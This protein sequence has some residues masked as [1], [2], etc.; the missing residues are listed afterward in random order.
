M[1]TN[2]E[3]ARTDR[4]DEGSCSFVQVMEVVGGKW[5]GTILYCL[6]QGPRRF[7]E[8]RREVAPISQK[9]LTQELRALERDG[10]VSRVHHPEIPPRV[11]YSLTELG[12]T[13]VSI[14]AA[15]DAWRV[16]MGE[17]GQARARYDARAKSAA[18]AKDAGERG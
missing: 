10:L 6:G 3:A 7:N 18:E 12:E 2:P 5:R 14:F 17:V 15:V 4:P 13:L 16:H 8:L 9:V 11:V 1:E